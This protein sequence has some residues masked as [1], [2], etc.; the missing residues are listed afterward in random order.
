MAIKREGWE[1][2]LQE[3]GV[4]DSSKME[5]ELYL[6]YLKFYNKTLP[7]ALEDA[8]PLL[9]Q[10]LTH[11][12]EWFVVGKAMG[13]MHEHPL[14]FEVVDPTPFVQVPLWTTPVAEDWLREKVTR[15]CE[16]GCLGKVVRGQE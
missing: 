7:A 8:W 12:E 10:C 9:F 14:V 4:W 2:F 5:D 16:I 11:L 15:D 13:V 6:R 1:T 3:R